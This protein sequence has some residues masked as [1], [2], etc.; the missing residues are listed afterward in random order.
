M[1]ITGSTISGNSASSSGGGIHFSYQTSGIIPI[2]GSNDAEK[3]TIC[4]NYKDGN[5]PSLDQQIRDGSGSLYD[6][7]KDTNDISAYCD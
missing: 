3:N 5:S 6:T 1:T 4:G 7:Y 2:G